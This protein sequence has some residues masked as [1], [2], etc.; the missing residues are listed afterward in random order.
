MP[1]PI[2][3][4]PVDGARRTR[5]RLEGLEFE[6]ASGER[7]VWFDAVEAATDLGDLERFRRMVVR[8]A[9]AAGWWEPYTLVHAEAVVVYDKSSEA[10]INELAR[11]IGFLHLT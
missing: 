4:A 11:I 1:D 6:I 10:S 2:T 8:T 3:S 7:T 9:R 5:H